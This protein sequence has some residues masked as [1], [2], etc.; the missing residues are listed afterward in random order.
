MSKYFTATNR[1]TGEDWKPHRGSYLVMYD[2]GNLAEV[3]PSDFYGMFITPL[4][5]KVWKV[6]I[7]SSFIGRID[8]L[9]GEQK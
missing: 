5:P 7:K 2:S 1:N 3:E 6:K 4:D 9:M 8:R